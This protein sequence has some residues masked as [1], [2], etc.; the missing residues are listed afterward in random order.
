MKD[1]FRLPHSQPQHD[2]IP[3]IPVHVGALASVVRRDNNEG[4]YL[5]CEATTS[6]EESKFRTPLF[7]I[8]PT[9]YV[10]IERLNAEGEHGHAYVKVPKQDR[11]P[12]CDDQE[13]FVQS[14]YLVALPALPPLN[15]A[16]VC[17]MRCVQRIALHVSI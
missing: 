15:A 1:K 14:K 8:L 4:T 11:F 2:L 16:S 17:L 9:M 13:G 12:L 7:L 10:R 5:R 6:Q 3:C